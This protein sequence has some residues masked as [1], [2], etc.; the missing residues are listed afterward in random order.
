MVLLHKTENEPEYKFDGRVNLD[1]DQS[2]WKRNF[3]RI[4]Y[5]DSPET[6]FEK[7]KASLLLAAK[8]ADPVYERPYMDMMMARI[9][10]EE[11]K[12]HEAFLT[13]Q[14]QFPRQNDERVL[15]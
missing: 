15:V 14:S 8:S 11:N 4:R 2:D 10:V 13:A 3:S 9:Q 12:W 1:V 6:L 7:E 5:F